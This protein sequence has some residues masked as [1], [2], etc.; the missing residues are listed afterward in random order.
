MPFILLLLALAHGAEVGPAAGDHGDGLRNAQV[1]AQR[2]EG[3]AKTMDTN[4]GQ[5][6]CGKFG[7]DMRIE[8]TGDGPVTIVM[9]SAVLKRGKKK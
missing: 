4:L 3:A 1:V 2:C 5:V 7:A 6:G 8:M 9:D